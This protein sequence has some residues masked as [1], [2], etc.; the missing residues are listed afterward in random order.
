MS[1]FSSLSDC[2]L[3]TPYRIETKRALNHC[4]TAPRFTA[5]RYQLS[6]ATTPSNGRWLR[7]PSLL[8]LLFCFCLYIAETSDLS[9]FHMP[10]IC[11]A[12]QSKST[13]SVFCLAISI[14]PFSLFLFQTRSGGAATCC[15]KL[16]AHIIC[17]HSISM[18]CSQSAFPR[19]LGIN[20]WPTRH[21][22]THCICHI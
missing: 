17:I 14:M 7:P 11:N 6:H 13:H 22:Q 18:S 8:S 19:I 5:N 9:I 1:T 10:N 3:R 21:H 2:S 20:T 12:T 15:A 16:S 4:L